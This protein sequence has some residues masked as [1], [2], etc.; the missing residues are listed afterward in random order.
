MT[1]STSHKEL[2]VVDDDSA[3][4]DAL[5]LFFTEAGFRV[6]TF[7]DGRSVIRA[8]R[9]ALPACIL[10]DMHL[11]GE[12]GLDILK[13]LVAGNF[14]VPI[15]IFSGRGDI[16]TAVAAIKN[17]AFDFFDKKMDTEKIVARVRNMVDAW[18][19]HRQNGHN[20]ITLLSAL[21]DFK[22]LTAREHEVMTYIASGGTTREVALS[23]GISR[24]T[25]DTH[26]ARIMK[27]LGA[28]NLAD[29]ARISFCHQK[30][31]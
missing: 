25:I 30:M 18:P 28:R 11:P 3:V 5:A 22:T 24:R 19:F 26:R 8:T 1:P 31:Q 9:K 20:V 29:L 4:R 15:L 2:F 6:T 27:K 23:L 12:S 13:Q 17:G 7:V 14:A 10:L 16:P 21:P